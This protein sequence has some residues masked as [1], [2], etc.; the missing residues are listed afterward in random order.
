M[1][2]HV[3]LLLTPDTADGVSRLMQ[4]IGREYVRY[5]NKTYQRSGTLFEGRFKSS[6]VDSEAYCLACYRYIE[7]NP[8]R[9]AMVISPEIETQLKLKLGSGKVGRPRKE[10]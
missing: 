10:I 1:T 6:L 9:A 2:I 5:I 7:L 3:H 8:V 4:D